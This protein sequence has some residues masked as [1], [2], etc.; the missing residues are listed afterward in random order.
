M[1]FNLKSRFFNRVHVYLPLL[2]LLSY[3]GVAYGQVQTLQGKL[4]DGTAY[5]IDHPDNWNGTVLI[6]LDYASRDPLGAG[7]GGAAN[8]YL[9]EH[10]YALAGTTRAVTGWAIQLAARNAVETLDIFTAKY[11]KPKYAVEF[12]SSMG[13]H[14]AALTLQAYPSRWN[15]AVAMCGGLSGTV[16]QWQGKFDGLWVAKTLLAPDSSLPV[17]NIPKDFQTTALP[18]WRQMFTTTG[19]TPQGKARAALAAILAQLPDW[20]DRS[21]PRPATDDLD[22]RESGLIQNLTTGLLPQAMSSRSQIETLSGGNISSNV[23]VDYAAL[24]KKVDKEGLAARIYAQAGLDLSADLATLAKAPRIPA[25]PSAIAYVASGVFDG[26]L[27]APV[28]T[29]SGIG[30]PISTV[31]S[32]Q[33][34]ETAVDRAHRESQLRQVY[35]ASAGH[36]GFTPAE[37][38]AAV[39]VLKHRLDSG[40]WDDT[41]VN[42]M[43][44]L[45]G[46]TTLGPSRFIEYAPADFGRPFTACDLD[47]TLKAAKIKPTETSGQE[48]P[49]CR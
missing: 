4:N 23:N 26:R 1:N 21:K 29:M 42:A 28:L 25:D 13:G 32:Q 38:V 48:L 8:R 35:T 18:A 20:S 33:S 44:Q 16:G 36:C 9:L 17:I 40:K 24:L 39:E 22:A 19:Q 30:D 3:F 47:K 12:G 5:R 43:N 41:S 37:T 2:F 31:A 7:E 6:G 49:Q 45:A 14:T 34:Y 27:A 11:G 46:T 15:G 10:G